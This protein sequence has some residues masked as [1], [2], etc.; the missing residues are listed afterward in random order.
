MVFIVL[1]W[2]CRY[3]L[4]Q[5]SREYSPAIGI[6]SKSQTVLA[7]YQWTGNKVIR[8]RVIRV[9]GRIEAR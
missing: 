4:G 2:S 9:R 6:Y 8:T 7:R 1:F 3:T 5:C